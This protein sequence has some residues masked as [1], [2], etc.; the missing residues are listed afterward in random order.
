MFRHASNYNSTILPWAKLILDDLRVLK[1]HS[2][3]KLDALGDP[4]ENPTEWWSLFRSFPSEWKLIVDEYFSI[5]DDVE[6]VAAREAVIDPIAHVCSVCNMSFA[7][8]KAML[9]HSRVKHK[10]IALPARCLPDTNTC[11]ICGAE[12]QDRIAVITHLCDYRIRSK[13]RG[14]SCAT[15]YEQSNPPTL[16][17]DV[18]DSL[19]AR[20]RDSRKAAAKAGYSHV[21]IVKP[22]KLPTKCSKGMSPFLLAQLSVSGCR[23]RVCGKTPAVIAKL[24][25]KPRTYAVVKPDSSPFARIRTKSCPVV[26]ATSTRAETQVSANFVC[27]QLARRRLST[28]T[29]S[30]LTIYHSGPELVHT[31]SG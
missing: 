8:S 24:K 30:S 21:R 26:V 10:L 29:L 25:F 22:A 5:A 1:A 3:H 31:C 15:L 4:A 20:D 6:D 28:K 9:Q 18:A 19:N 16:P 12:Y 23:R 17:S 27:P 13:I 11:P 7:S 2:H 14:T